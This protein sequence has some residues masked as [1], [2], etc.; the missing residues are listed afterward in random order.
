MELRDV[1]SVCREL[2]I[3]EKDLVLTNEKTTETNGKKDEHNDEIITTLKELLHLNMEILK[4]INT[5][6]NI[7]EDQNERI[8]YNQQEILNLLK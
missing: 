6:G 3:N 5:F 7:H 2:N 1:K 8:I 4:Y